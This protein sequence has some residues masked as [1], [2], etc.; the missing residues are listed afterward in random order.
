MKLLKKKKIK[1][2]KRKVFRFLRPLSDIKLLIF[3]I[4]IVII[5][6]GVWNLTDAYFLPDHFLISNMLSIALGILILFLSDSRLGTLVGVSDCDTE[7]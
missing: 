1:K 7:E 3:A 4:A 2:I 6:R 5:W